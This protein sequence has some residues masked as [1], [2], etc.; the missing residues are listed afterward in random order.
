MKKLAC[1]FLAF[2]RQTMKACDSNDSAEAFVDDKQS[3]VNKMR[4]I[5][6]N[7]SS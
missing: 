2:V 3:D 4:R 1:D 5:A 7:E 6:F